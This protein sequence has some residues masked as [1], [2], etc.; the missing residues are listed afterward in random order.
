[1]SWRTHR[2]VVNCGLPAV[3]RETW[4]QVARATAAHSTVTV[5]DK[6][7]CRFLESS[8]LRGLLFGVPIIGGPRE[9]QITREDR[10]DGKVLR[11]SHDGYARE[12]GVVHN[13]ALRLAAD[14]LM[15]EGEDSFK[16]V[17]GETLPPKGPDEFAIRFHL[18][19]AV[20]AS[21]LQ[22]GHGVIL[23][24]PDREVWTFN[25]FE[26]AVE[27][28]ESVF[29]SG[30]DGPRRTVQIVI[31]GHARRQPAVQ[32]SFRHTPPAQAAP[33]KPTGDE[34]ELPL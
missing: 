29:L 8:S 19:P 31:Y 6:S 28:E 18:H 2:L 5:N 12:F 4:R 17:R 13:R 22:D 34:P 23:L 10:A 24:L 16:P 3:N 30:P 7:S 14:G 11:A 1:L 26:D 27:I 33:V 21:R 15:L 9:V 32:W 20:K 25:A